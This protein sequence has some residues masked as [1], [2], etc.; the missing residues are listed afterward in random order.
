MLTQYF[1]CSG[2]TGMDQTIA[3]WDTL[4]QTCVFASGGIYGSRS[5]FNCVRSKKRRCTI[6]QAGVRSVHIWQKLR[7]NMSR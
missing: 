7:R 4:C 2:G 1:S 3:R 6:F 5:A